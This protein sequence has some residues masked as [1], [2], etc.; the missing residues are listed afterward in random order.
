MSAKLEN[1]LTE[2]M[3]IYARDIGYI[4][5]MMTRLEASQNKA[6]TNHWS[7]VQASTGSIQED[8]KELK[9][10]FDKLVEMFSS[11]KIEFSEQKMNTVWVMRFFWIVATASV[12]AIITGLL[13][14]VLK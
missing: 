13:E 8:L 14:L 3:A 5:E 10:E 12:M 1:K 6:E 9:T 4:K 7:H 11:H 2:H